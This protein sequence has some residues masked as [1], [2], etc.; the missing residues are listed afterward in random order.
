MMNKYKH[1]CVELK[2]AQNSITIKLPSEDNWESNLNFIIKSIHNSFKS[3][4]NLKESEWVL[5]ANDTILHKHNALQFGETLS[6]QIP[7]P[8]VLEIFTLH[9]PPHRP[10]ISLSPSYNRT[11]SSDINQA[12]EAMISDMS[13]QE[14]HSL[15]HVVSNPTGHHDFT[16]SWRHVIA[17]IK[18]EMWPKLASV[19][20]ELLNNQN[21]N[22]N[23]IIEGHDLS[24]ECIDRGSYYWS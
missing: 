8:A 19:M 9:A 16:M 21:K 5:I 12:T 14:I 13:T 2:C 11:Q 17:C 18:H 7:P 3:I 15:K 20:Q 4:S 24:E 22:E 6:T 1:G 10:N 23:Q